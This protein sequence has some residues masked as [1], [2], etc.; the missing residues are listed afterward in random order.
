[1]NNER[2]SQINMS[3]TFK[4]SESSKGQA[5][6]TGYSD[7]NASVITIP[8]M[9]DGKGVCT[10]GIKAF[11]DMP[12]LHTVRFENLHSD[13]EIKPSAFHNCTNLTDIIFPDKYNNDHCRFRIT[14]TGLEAAIEKVRFSKDIPLKI[15]EDSQRW[16]LD[17][18]DT[19]YLK[20]EPGFTGIGC[21][22]F[23]FTKGLKKIDL[24]STL[25]D[26]SARAFKDVVQLEKIVIPESVREIQDDTFAGCSS[27]KEIWLPQRLKKMGYGM[28]ADCSSL[29]KF[30]IPDGITTLENHLLSGCIS[31]KTLVLGKDVCEVKNFALGACTALKEIILSPQN[32]NFVSDKTGLFSSDRKILY[33]AYSPNS[34][35]Y[36]V[37]DGVTEIAPNAFSVNQHFRSIIL[38]GSLRIIWDNAF[39]CAMSLEEIS[40][41]DQI[42][43]I[44]HYCFAGCESLRKIHLPDQLEMIGEFAF[45]DCQKLSILNVPETLR[46]IDDF[47]FT[48]CD[49]LPVETQDLLI[50]HSGSS[51]SNV[52]IF[53]DY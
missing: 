27:L 22:A 20:L 49:E 17:A 13:L 51:G 19:E 4:Y 14:R 46:R 34:D 47:A 15:Y 48:Y 31:L 9:L 30:V 42:K 16:L 5:A 26:I 6:I 28:L 52:R 32:R 40:I 18:F 41:P 45:Q 37:P 44:P 24:P 12:H 2:K 39:V 43:T 38:P 11:A 3:A 53:D 35:I 7:K 50:R 29:K 8:E 1:M 21:E 23:R 10:I 33:A 25:R 36:R